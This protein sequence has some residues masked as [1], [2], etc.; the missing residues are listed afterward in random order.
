MLKT[1]KCQTC[2]CE[3]VADTDDAKQFS[4]YSPLYELF[5]PLCGRKRICH[6]LVRKKV[7]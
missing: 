6:I 7:Q 1:Y 3:F 4:F 2:H 5:C